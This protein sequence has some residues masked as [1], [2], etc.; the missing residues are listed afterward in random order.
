MQAFHPT[1]ERVRPALRPDGFTPPAVR[2]SLRWR[3]PVPELVAD[4][5]GLQGPQPG[6]TASRD[7]VDHMRTAFSGAFGPE[8]VEVMVCPN[9]EAGHPTTIV[10]GY[11]TS[12]SAHAH[13]THE[14]Q[15]EQWWHSRA[16]GTDDVG[17]WRETLTCPYDRHETIYSQNSY[18]IGL[19]RTPDTDI[20]QITDNG[21]P[22]AARDRFP[23]TAVEDIAS[24]LGVAVRYDQSINPQGRRVFVL[25]PLNTLVMRSGQFW[26]NSEPEQA[27]DYE[28]ALRP[29]LDRGMDYLAAHAE[30]GCIYLRQM[31]NVDA[32][33]TQ[34]RET[35]V[36]AVFQ[37][38]AGLET[39][40]ADHTTHHAIYGHQIAMGHK[41]GSR[42]DVITW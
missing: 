6:S 5:F 12:T 10:V 41:Y 13:W 8:A 31:I 42:R 22:G 17:L 40:A 4:W 19:G 35:S 3:R 15:W 27:K 30:T 20:V 38:Y 21:Y 7:F 11:W 2:Y 18:R 33:F 39:W 36:Y 24:P 26:H 29:K 14:P 34:R 23:I 25:N 16:R 28:T 32:D 9:D 1:Y 37:D